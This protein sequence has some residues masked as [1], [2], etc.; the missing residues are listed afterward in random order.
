MKWNNAWFLLILFGL[1]LLVAPSSFEGTSEAPTQLVDG[2][3]ALGDSGIAYRHGLRK[4]QISES[5]FFQDEFIETTT[6]SSTSNDTFTVPIVKDYTVGG[7]FYHRLVNASKANPVNAWENLTREEGEGWEGAFG[8]ETIN[9]RIKGLTEEPYWNYTQ[10]YEAGLAGPGPTNVTDVSWWTDGARVNSS[11]DYGLDNTTIFF[12][13]WKGEILGNMSSEW[14]IVWYLWWNRSTGVVEVVFQEFLIPWFIIVEPVYDSLEFVV[15]AKTD[16]QVD[17]RGSVNVSAAYEE[18]VWGH[19][20]EIVLPGH[21]HL[22]YRAI[23]NATGSYALSSGFS[24]SMRISLNQSISV[25]LTNGTDLFPED[26]LPGWLQSSNTTIE[27]DWSFKY[28][29]NAE[30]FGVTALQ[31]IVQGILTKLSTESYADLVIWGGWKPGRMFGYADVDGNNRLD[32]MLNGSEIA[33]PD[34]VFAMG[35]PEG[36]RLEGNASATSVEKASFGYED[37]TGSS[38]TTAETNKTTQTAT[39]DYVHGFDP[40]QYQGKTSLDWEEPSYDAETGKA[41]FD[42]TLNRK[43]W[44]VYWF[45]ANR[46]YSD[47]FIDRMDFT[48]AYSLEIDTENGVATL[49]NDYSQS[50]VTDPTLAAMVSDLSLATYHRDIFL[51]ISA[52]EKGMDGA[53]SQEADVNS[54]AI[55]GVSVATAVFGDTK[56]KYTIGDPPIENTTQTTVLNLLTMSGQVGD[57]STI[58]GDPEGNPFVSPVAQRV[59]LG[60]VQLTA[61]GLDE[62]HV[63]D[64]TWMLS[65]NIVVTSYPNWGGKGPLVHDPTFTATFSPKAADEP[66]SGPATD[67]DTSSEPEPDS[68]PGFVGD[69]AAVFVIG[70][71]LVSLSLIRRRTRK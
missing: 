58:E 69:S 40:T 1:L 59:A 53:R 54:I 27:G 33:T 17:I 10:Q 26:Q 25:R 44:P 7:V 11:A 51:S 2:W 43:D 68:T 36:I 48:D 24:M 70:S 6:N 45:A 13:N 55:G 19:D 16:S 37:S 30:F 64:V 57:T 50:A 66:S 15:T 65:E 46:S 9:W 20:V 8:N 42:W 62:E 61:D 14:T 52:L 35:L 3:Q 49:S 31:G 41:Q 63:G 23:E 56:A 21:Y 18:T 39:F 22:A 47:T 28:E 5:V 67:T 34:V 71:L 12:V 29:E 32:L 4:T 60:L 38:L